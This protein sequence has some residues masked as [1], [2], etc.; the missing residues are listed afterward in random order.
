MILATPVGKIPPLLREIAPHLS[1]NA[2]VTDVG[3]SKRV[4]VEAMQNIIYS[5]GAR[6][7]QIS[8]GEHDRI[9][10][11]LSHLPKLLSVALVNVLGKYSAE[12]N[13]LLSL[14]GKG[15]KDTTRIAAGDP[16]LWL[17]IFESNKDNLRDALALLLEELQA[18][19]V[20]LDGGDKTYLTNSL[21]KAAALR[22][23]LSNK[24]KEG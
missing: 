1:S 24:T 15:F 9:M 22:G 8:P 3:S 14:A 4:I 20:C 5:I 7:M 19:A 10:A 17:D 11:P 16:Q 2:L 23:V 6:P 18:I 12:D 21:E 13:T